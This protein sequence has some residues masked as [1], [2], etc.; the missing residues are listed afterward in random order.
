LK[1]YC[2][3]WSSNEADATYAHD[4][5]L[6]YSS[7]GL[8]IRA[9]GGSGKNNGQSIRLIK[10]STTLTHGQTSHYTGN[11]GYVY[12]TIC[13]G[14]QEWLSENLIETLYRDGTA[15]LE[16]T[17]TTEWSVLTTG[18]RCS[19]SNDETNAFTTTTVASYNVG[20]LIGAENR[21][22]I[23]DDGK[24]FLMDSASDRREFI[25]NTTKVG[26]YI[27]VDT[28]GLISNEKTGWAVE[29]ITIPADQTTLVDQSSKVF[30]ADWLTR[31]G[32]T[33][34]PVKRNAYTSGVYAYKDLWEGEK[35]RGRV[36][37]V[38]FTLPTQT[39]GKVEVVAFEIGM[40]VSK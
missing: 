22:F 29:T 18:A 4:A 25:G 32:V 27:T 35:M 20:G 19:Y 24:L 2:Y 30:T 16:V 34:A 6:S 1:K 3:L 9:S 10:D 39:S 21:F 33:R 37:K 13:I 14:G 15:I 26:G 40:T 23:V 36:V 28:V 7:A 38:K 8:F 5:I 17:G 11:D 31:E 12:D